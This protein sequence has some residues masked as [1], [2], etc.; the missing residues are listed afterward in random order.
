MKEVLTKLE[1]LEKSLKKKG[2][3]VNADGA[4]PLLPTGMA[5][6]PTNAKSTSTESVTSIRESDSEDNENG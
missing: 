5:F 4:G 6:V 3:K 2:S 1:E